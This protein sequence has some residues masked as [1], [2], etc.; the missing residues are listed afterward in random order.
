MIRHCVAH[1]F[2]AAY[3]R[4]SQQAAM[5]EPGEGSHPPSIGIRECG[6]PGCEKPTLRSVFQFGG[7]GDRQVKILKATNH[8]NHTF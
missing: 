3:G 6:V 4:S 2:G 8:A 1:P 7:E 5:L